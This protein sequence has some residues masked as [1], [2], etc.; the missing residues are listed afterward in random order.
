M[1]DSA[2]AKCIAVNPTYPEMMA[3][4]ANDPY[5]RIFDRRLIKPFNVEVCSIFI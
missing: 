3:V 2:E 5:A 4:G 1:G